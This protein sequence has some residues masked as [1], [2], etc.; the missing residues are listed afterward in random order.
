MSGRGGA[1][2]PTGT[3]PESIPALLGRFSAGSPP[4]GTAGAA[5]TI[6]LRQGRREVEV[7]LIERAEN[8]TDPAS[9]QVGLPGG[10]VD[11]SDS[12]MA[13]TAMRELREEVGLSETDLSGPPRYVETRDARRFRLKV[14]IFAGELASRA[15][16]PTAASRAEVA[17]VFWLPRSALAHARQVPRDTPLGWV[18]V[19]ATVYDGH[20]LWGFTRRV[21][22]D[23][24]GYPPEDELGGLA[25]AP[26]ATPPP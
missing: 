4:V 21:V 7:L 8:P 22:R 2:P 6:V 1:A 10:H 17:H 5:V 13:R 26:H 14:A 18:E 12:S 25:F 9:G 15:S 24:F 16:T 20:V 23:F 19:T 11:D 3:A